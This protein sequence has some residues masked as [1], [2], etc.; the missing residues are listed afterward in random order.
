[1]AFHWHGDFFDVPHGSVCLARSERTACQAF[2]IAGVAYGLL[3]HLE[4]TPEIVRSMVREFEP[5]WRQARAD[6]A[7]I[8]TRMRDHLGA[9]RLHG[10][11]LAAGWT[12]LVAQRAEPHP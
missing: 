3:C 12:D 4:V 1:M 10:R 6:G 2:R 11:R 8:L 7:A 9:L 5:E